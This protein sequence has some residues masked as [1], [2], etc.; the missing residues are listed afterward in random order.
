MLPLSGAIS[1]LG[2]LTLANVGGTATFSNNVAAAALTA[3][4]TVANIAFTGS[5][6]TFSAASTLSQ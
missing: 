1:G 4:N 5:T 6:N 2:N 3:A